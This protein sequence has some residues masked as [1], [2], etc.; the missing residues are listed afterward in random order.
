MYKS[1]MRLKR[2]ILEHATNTIIQCSAMDPEQMQTG[3]AQRI[4]GTCR[5]SGTGNRNKP[6]DHHRNRKS[7]RAQHA[8]NKAR[9]TDP[10][11]IRKTCSRDRIHAQK[12]RKAP[13]TRKHASKHRTPYRKTNRAQIGIYSIVKVQESTTKERDRISRA[14][15]YYFHVFIIFPSK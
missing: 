7:S 2:N 4:R 9:A 15:L 12:T 1:L 11:R 10:H 13:R 8:G 5:T 14:Q 3:T 6:A